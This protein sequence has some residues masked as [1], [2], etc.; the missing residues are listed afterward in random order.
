MDQSSTSSSPE[1]PTLTGQTALHPS[2]LPER[3]R[4]DSVTSLFAFLFAC[5][6]GNGK[7]DRNGAGRFV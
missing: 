1:G 5:P 6:G 4:V 2:Y 7:I 3:G